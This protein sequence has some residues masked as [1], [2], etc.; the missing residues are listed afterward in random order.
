[1]MIAFALNSMMLLLYLKITSDSK[2]YLLIVA[3]V[4]VM[5]ERLWLESFAVR[6]LIFCLAAE[7]SNDSGGI[8]FES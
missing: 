6:K 8:A 1:M 3:T 2:E 7:K 4:I 5:L